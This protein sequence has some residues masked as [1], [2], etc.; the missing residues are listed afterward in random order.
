M[1][2]FGAERPTFIFPMM[3]AWGLGVAANPQYAIR[4]MSASSR[5]TA[6]SML[7][8]APLIV[9]WIYVCLTLTGM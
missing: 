3:L 4:I 8:L 7:V 9:G 2:P 6:Y 1:R 5:R